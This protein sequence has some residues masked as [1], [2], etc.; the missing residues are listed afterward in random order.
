M[1]VP[2]ARQGFHPLSNQ[3]SYNN[4]ET[5]IPLTTVGSNSSS[6][7]MRRSREDGVSPHDF[8][9]Q[10]TFRKD[11]EKSGLYNRTIGRRKRQNSDPN[12]IR[13]VNSDEDTSVTAMG[14]IYQKIVTFSPTTRYLVY[15]VPVGSLLAVPVVV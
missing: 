3:S 5:D 9:P 12:H 14:R 15:I 13:R 11:G 10:P 1:A 6:T 8:A 2:S 4:I 7:S